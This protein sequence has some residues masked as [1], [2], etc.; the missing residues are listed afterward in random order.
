M[1]FRYCPRPSRHYSNADCLPHGR[2]GPSLLSPTLS[3][4]SRIQQ[5]DTR[6]FHLRS[7]PVLLLHTQSEWFPASFLDVVT[8]Q[9][10]HGVVSDWYLQRDVAHVDCYWGRREGIWV[11]VGCFAVYHLGANLYTGDICTVF[12]YV[13]AKVKDYEGRDEGEEVRRDLSRVCCRA[14]LKR[15]ELQNAN[16][17]DDTLARLECW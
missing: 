9:C 3:F 11:G 8:V 12:A 1:K 13:K 7:D 10:F 5:H 16:G 2:A 14:T 17:K 15:R 6:T 4:L